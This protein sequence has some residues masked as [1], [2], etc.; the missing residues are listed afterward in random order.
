MFSKA[1]DASKVALVK[2]CQYL[3][4]HHFKIIDSQVHTS[5]MESMGAEMIPRDLFISII[6][7]HVNQQPAPGKWQ[8]DD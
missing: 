1:T 7:E 8:L 6:E 4:R 5:H 3:T 2:L